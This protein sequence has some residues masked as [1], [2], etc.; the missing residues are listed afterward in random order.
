LAETMRGSHF[1]ASAQDLINRQ[2]IV[3][4]SR[5][6]HLTNAPIATPEIPVA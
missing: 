3:D 6:R 1:N 2:H 5:A 4:E